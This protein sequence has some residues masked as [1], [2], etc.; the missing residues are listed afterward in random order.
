[1]HYD[2]LLYRTTFVY[3][4][5]YLFTYSFISVHSNS[6]KHGGKDMHIICEHLRF[7]H[8]RLIRRLLCWRFYARR[9]RTCKIQCNQDAG[10]GCSFLCC[11]LVVQWGLLHSIFHRPSAGRVHNNVLQH[12]GACCLFELLHQS[13]HLLYPISR[14]TYSSR[15][16]VH[17]CTFAIIGHGG[18]NVAWKCWNGQNCVCACMHVFSTYVVVHHLS[19]NALTLAF[20]RYNP[21]K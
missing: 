6:D 5:A 9:L 13:N 12:H 7:H 15:C 18:T 14:G 17:L 20:I 3:L 11:L 8:F 2:L 16:L 21:R 19:A 4:F 1:M 10:N